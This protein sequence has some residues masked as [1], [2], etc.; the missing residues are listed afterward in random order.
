MGRRKFPTLDYCCFELINKSQ[1]SKVVSVDSQHVDS[2][3]VVRPGHVSRLGM[4]ISPII[5]A[6]SRN[7]S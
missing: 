4:M 5:E 3:K 1:M 7:D 6:V 2:D